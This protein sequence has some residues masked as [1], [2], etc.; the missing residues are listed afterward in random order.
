M[1]I[2]STSNSL[3]VNWRGLLQSVFSLQAIGFSCRLFHCVPVFIT[4]EC[5]IATLSSQKIPLGA[6]F[7]GIAAVYS[8]PRTCETF[9]LPIRLVILISCCAEAEIKHIRLEAIPTP[10]KNFIPFK[11]K[12]S[13]Q[14]K[15]CQVIEI[16][17]RTGK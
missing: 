5:V 6:N 13:R 17:I 3:P 14:S 7:L 4:Y 15:R 16:D 1:M 8:H 12:A 10:Q 9:S 2:S 11:I